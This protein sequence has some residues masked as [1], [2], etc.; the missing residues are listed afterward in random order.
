LAKEQ[1]NWMN[2]LA[3]YNG[4]YGKYWYPERVMDAWRARW[5]GR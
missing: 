1:G 2:A 5:Q 3:R 4:S